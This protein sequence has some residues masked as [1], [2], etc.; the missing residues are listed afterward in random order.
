MDP[1]ATAIP[2]ITL[3]DADCPVGCPRGDDPV[4]VGRDRL[5]DLPG[6][7]S[8]VRCRTCGLMRTNPRPT[9]EAIGFYYPQE[10]AAYHVNYSVPKAGRIKPDTAGRRLLARLRRAVGL[11]NPKL[12]PLSPPGRLLEL[13]A[14]NG[15][16]LAHAIGK[17]WQVRG[18]E[19]S[20]DAV[21]HARSKGLDVYC[22]TVESAPVPAEPY[23]LIVGWMVFEHLHDPCAGFRKL[24]DFVRPD[25]WLALSVPDAGSY[26][27]RA[28]GPRWYALQV[29]GHMSHFT[30]ATLGTVLD[31][32]GWTLRH[33]IWHP[34]P[35]NT[36]QSLR[37]WA[38]DNG[39]PRLA[40]WLLDVIKGR[41]ARLLY[42]LAGRI[43]AW[44]HQSGRMTV[45]ASRKPS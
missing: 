5:H 10:Y 13:G 11:E 31:R 33:I 24:H 25:G 4:L 1:S 8:V 14:A 29:P 20:P 15:K 40:Q 9:A 27:F 44:T 6:E 7:F 30:P 39:H 2:S 34:N 37:Y 12:L 41:R 17:G 22:G 18:I 3:E 36:L 16:Y 28:F 19:F 38:L 35:D 26:E 42:R 23:D 21:Q 32:S 45:W 43:L